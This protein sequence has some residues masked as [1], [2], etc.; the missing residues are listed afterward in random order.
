MLCR[1]L[2]Y[3]LSFGR[4]EKNALASLENLEATSSYR[5]FPPRNYIFF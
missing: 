3:D 5:D 2:I 4:L 1:L